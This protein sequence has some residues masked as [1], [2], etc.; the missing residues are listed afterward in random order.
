MGGVENE[1]DALVQEFFCAA[2][3]PD[4]IGHILGFSQVSYAQI[5]GSEGSSFDL[6]IISRRSTV[7]DLQPWCTESTQRLLRMLQ[8]PLIL[9]RTGNTFRES[10]SI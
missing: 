9:T 8:E 10:V 3:G 2:S 7:I 1:M 4:V 6:L 5:G